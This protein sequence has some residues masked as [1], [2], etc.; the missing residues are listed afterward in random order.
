MSEEMERLRAALERSVQLQSHYAKLLNEYDG[1]NRMQF[2]DADQWL[3]RLEQIKVFR[4]G[5]KCGSF[6][7]KAKH[8]S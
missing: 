3:A 8:G 6:N 5:G 7:D 1:G 4:S 2:D